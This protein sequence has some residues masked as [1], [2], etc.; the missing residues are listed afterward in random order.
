MIVKN[1][2][3]I[4]VRLLDSVIDLIDGYCI[5][6]TGS[7]DNTISIIEEY[8]R[9]KN[10]EGKVFQEAFQNFGYNRTVALRECYNMGNMD[11]IL[12]LDADMKLI[13][14]IP[15]VLSF[16]KSLTKYAYYI[17][18]G[19]NSFYNT[20]IRIVRNNINNI[21]WG[22]THEYLKIPINSEEGI[23]KKEELFIN[24][25]G[26][27]GSKENKFIRDVKLLEKGLKEEKDNPRYLFYLANS[28]RD[29]GKYKEAIVIY[30]KRISVKGW[31]EELWHSYYSIGN[32]YLI[33]KDTDMAISFWL[34]A[35]EIIPERIENLYKIVSTYR[36]NKQYKLAYEFYKIAKKVLIDNVSN[37]A[38]CNHLFLEN[39]IYNYKLDIELLIIGYYV[40]FD[41][42]KLNEMSMLLLN[43][44]YGIDMPMYYNIL[45]NYKYYAPKL[46]INSNSHNEELISELLTVGK[47]HNSSNILHE[48]EDMYESTPSLVRVNDRQILV[49]KR[50]INYKID[51][52]GEYI[53]KSNIITKNILGLLVF[54]NNKWKL[55]KEEYF[56]YDKT[57]DG[58]YI[59]VEDVKLFYNNVVKY[60]G[61]RVTKKGEFSVEYGKYDI[62]NNKNI[63]NKVLKI[64]QQAAYE[65]NW[66]LFIN[67][68]QE[69]YFIY[70]WGPLTICKKGND[71]EIT[72]KKKK[73]MPNLFNKLR[74]STN[75]ITIGD[76]IWFICHY[77]S[78]E[79]R[80]YYYHMIVVLD[81]R[82]LS[83]KRY[84]K[85][86]TFS[87]NPVEYTL[88]FIY[89]EELKTFVIGYSV[90]D[91]KTHYLSINKE[92]IDKL[93]IQ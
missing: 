72:I 56:D 19:N 47:Y 33:L 10:K 17:T 79:E 73:E 8:F 21:Y 35:Y 51:D 87:G 66:V 70:K 74:G 88:G 75:G 41:T 85:M 39:D 31:I 3:K 50:Y 46:K 42:N 80:R 61:N 83:L 59:G 4:I 37:N 27:G 14:N 58:K 40:K 62:N 78:Y 53:N 49:C 44:T 32:C 25:I 86:F 55:I 23:I 18:Q 30:K 9:D 54:E 91:N 11:Y 5:C 6:D 48:I 64:E 24:D 92:E 76:E 84:T 34:Q 1:E 38:N 22:V 77:V 67:N 13:I 81:N 68:K 20:N 57:Q 65:K 90:N 29:L 28:Y 45:Q 16:K 12:L 15:D 43:R 93:F 71:E 69:E 26:D 36:I 63:E 89:F 7:S 60:S 52:K 2:S 82:T